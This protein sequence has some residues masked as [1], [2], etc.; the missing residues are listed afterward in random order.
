MSDHDNNLETFKSPKLFNDD[1]K[2]E[3]LKENNVL[4]GRGVIS[5]KFRIFMLLELLG[6]LEDIC[7]D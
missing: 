2:K 4:A 6:D 7:R 1:F 5:S 3:V